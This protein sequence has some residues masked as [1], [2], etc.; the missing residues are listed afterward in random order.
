MFCLNIPTSRLLAALAAGLAAAPAHA[1]PASE[2]DA[3]ATRFALQSETG[4]RIPAGAFGIV[5]IKRPRQ[6]TL[7]QLRGMAGLGDVILR[8]HDSRYCLTFPLRFVA[9][10]FG[11]TTISAHRVEPA[12]L[13]LKSR[14]VAKAL[15]NGRDVVSDMYRV[16]S[17]EMADVDIVIKSGL[18]GDYGFVLNPGSGIMAEIW[19]VDSHRIACTPM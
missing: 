3:M 6:A 2:A 4:Q 5:E 17:E 19:G 14:R 9:G 18:N 10:D 13:L 12:V 16:G 8:S 15:A 1:G 11:G 7:L